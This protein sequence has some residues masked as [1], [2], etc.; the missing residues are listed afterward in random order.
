MMTAVK[1]V[2]ATLLVLC[3]G[4]S[5]TPPL[6][7]VEA[8]GLGFTIGTTNANNN[9]RKNTAPSP[10]SSQSSGSTVR[11]GNASGGGPGEG[12]AR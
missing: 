9:Q 11:A 12:Q 4:C 7:H 10:G 2:A 6:V 5:S 3:A 8:F 1:T